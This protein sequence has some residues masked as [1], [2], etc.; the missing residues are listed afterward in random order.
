M[1]TPEERIEALLGEMRKV[2][3]RLETADGDGGRKA[4]ALDGQAEIA[5]KLTAADEDRELAAI[6]AKRLETLEAQ[7]ESMARLMHDNRSASKASIVGGSQ[8]APKGPVGLR[9]RSAVKASSFME[10]AFEDGYEGGTFFDAL[11]NARGVG[12]DGHFDPSLM[13][14][15]KASLGNLS[16]GYF[17]GLPS[18]STAGQGVF[19]A[20]ASFNSDGSVNKATLGTTGAAGGFVLPNNLVDRVL[21]PA[22]QRAV[23]QQLVTVIN[24]VAV[25]GVDQPYRTSAAQRATFQD[26]GTTK[27]NV[28][29]AYGTYS[30]YLG[31]IAIIYDIG[32]QFARFSS[33]AAEQ[34]VMDEVTRGIILGENYY[35]IAGAGTGT[36]GYTGDPTT[37]VYTA[38]NSG[39]NTY[40]TAFAA[41]S[42][43]TLAGSFA[44]ALT[45]ASSA[46]ASRSREPEAWVVDSTTFWTAIDQGSDTA[47]FWVNPAGGPTG[48][49]RTAS[50]ALSYWGVPV[51]YDANLNTNTGTTKIAIGGEWSQLKLYRG[52]ELRIDTS[53]QAG[54]RWDL[55]LIGF[56]GEEEI[57]FNASSAVSVG[58][59]QLITSTIP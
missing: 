37:G 35:M 6:K 44:S 14:T 32:K 26:W 27:T 55:N 23:L 28:N 58:A 40:K 47:G 8:P 30:A 9:P 24:G 25:R 33:G 48:F 52:M 12:Y 38:L 34:D 46:L 1:S 5:D 17:D 10:A 13:Q 56:R 4:A 39:S 21:K 54:T 11:L 43:S 18:L 42:N 22:T 36:G 19:D 57:G 53:D 20:K 3:E 51:Y 16:L 15:G 50:G 49:T 2:N 45:S 59:L 31:T 7:V 29:L 41:A